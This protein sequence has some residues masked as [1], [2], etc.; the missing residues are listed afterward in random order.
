ML[1]RGLPCPPPA[2]LS[3]S[4][5]KPEGSV[6][7]RIKTAGAAYVMES[8]EIFIFYVL[9]LIYHRFEDVNFVNF[10]KLRNEASVGVLFTPKQQKNT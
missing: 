2:L 10:R 6:F 1:V 3:Q 4:L 5:V 8:K 9:W 7:E